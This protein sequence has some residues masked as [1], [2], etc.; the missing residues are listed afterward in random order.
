MSGTCEECNGKLGCFSG[1]KA[2][3]KCGKILCSTCAGKHPLIPF[4]AAK[5][6]ESND[7]SKNGT[8]QSYCKECFQETSVLDLTKTYDV[9]HPKNGSAEAMTFLMVH[10]GGGSR[11]MFRPHAEILS[12]KGFRSILIDLPGHGSLVEMPLTLDSCATT[13]QEVLDKEKLDKRHVIYVGGSLGAYTGFYV[14]EKL[15]DRFCGAVLMDCGQNVGPDCSL[16]ASVGL[17]VLRFASKSMSNKGLLQTMAGISKKSPANWKLVESAF[18][19]GMFFDQ[20]VQQIECLHSVQPADHIPSYNFPI[21]FFNG[22][23][24]YRDSEDKWLRLCKDQQR[25]SLKVY[26]GGDHFLSHDS[27]FV[28]DVIDKMARF[29]SQCA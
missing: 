4:D 2:C 26:E 10:G 25:S 8:V 13:V 15:N 16:K 19:A 7:L 23:E 18:G 3:V 22:S 11:A 9:V 29:S 5:P 27:R 20:A 14:L 24:D 17:I 28:D 12:T 1:T 6:E 21:L